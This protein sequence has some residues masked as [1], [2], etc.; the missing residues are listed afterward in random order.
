MIN[1]L[2]LAILISNSEDI[3]LLET[4]RVLTDLNVYFML[5]SVKSKAG[6]RAKLAGELM[7]VV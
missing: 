7:A 5:W 3:L 6:W 4:K 1:P 2:E